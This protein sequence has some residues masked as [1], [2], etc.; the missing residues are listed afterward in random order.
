VD[1]SWVDIDND[2][3]KPV[4]QFYPCFY[5]HSL[6][7][8]IFNQSDIK[9]DGNLFSDT[10]YKS[11]ALPPVDGQ[12]KRTPFKK[13]LLNGTSQTYSAGLGT[14][15][16]IKG[17]TVRQS[18]PE[19]WD[20]IN[21]R[22]ITPI[23]A[24]FYIYVTLT[25]GSATSVRVARNGRVILGSG[26]TLTLGVKKRVQLS[27][28]YINAVPVAG[29]YYEL[30]AL[31]NI[32]TPFTASFDIEYEIPEVIL[33][34][35]YI[36]PGN[37]LPSI[38]SID[39]IKFLV[40]LFGCAVYF[41]STSKTITLTI[42]EKLRLED[43][44]DWSEYFVSHSSDY[45]D[46]AAHNFITWASSSDSV[47]TKYNQINTLK[48]GDGDMR[49]TN[50][51]LEQKEIAKLPFAPSA[52]SLCFNNVYCLDIPLI[53]L[54]DE[55]DPIDFTSIAVISLGLG[56]SRFTTGVPSVLNGFE[57]V[58]ITNGDGVNIGYYMAV[59]GGGGAT[60]ED[61][62]FPFVSTDTGKIWR[63]K[64]NY[65]KV[66]PRVISIA[67]SKAPTDFAQAPIYSVI[68]GTPTQ[69]TSLAYATF[70]KNFTGLPIDQWKN[71]LAIDNPNSG[72]FTD[73][74][75]KELYFNKISRFIKNPKIRAVMLLPDSVYQ[76]FKFDQFIYLKTEK[77]TGYFFVDSIINY[78]DS[79]TPVEI[80]LYML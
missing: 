18:D 63:Q 38:Q 6:T 15:E 44:Y 64:I 60:Y 22:F 75:I 59:D 42:I 31:N 19:T 34:D 2:P 13:V 56:T 52:S 21:K 11:M 20:D 72:N 41:D 80:N 25:S 23:Q 29:D 62:T 54:V 3:L 30:Y 53:N 51:L 76:R 49:T 4:I 47:I 33:S 10:L 69:I 79:N 16:K 12:I 14:A 5:L 37:F 66:E 71:N 40:N 77:L 65:Q 68:F 70:T 28:E 7:S 8:E 39:I 35:D 50:T 67:P 55:G 43:A 9:K 45:S 32:T 58:R 78:V 57:V 27:T 1:V 17:L 74:T 73:P 46:N 24:G 36:N 48:F 26:T 61:I